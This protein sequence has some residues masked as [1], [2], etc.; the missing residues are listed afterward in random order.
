MRALAGVMVVLGLVLGPAAAGATTHEPQLSVTATNRW[1]GYFES[2]PAIHSASASW[3]VPTLHCTSG[4]TMSSTWVGVGGLN[5]SVLLQAGLFDNCLSGVP[6]NGG[7]AEAYPG[8]TQSFGLLLRPGDRIVATVEDVSGHWQ[9]RVTDATTHHT[10][11]AGA[12]GYS[13]G[14][15]AEWM[16]EAYGQPTYPITNFGSER[17]LSIRVNGA[18]ARPP[19][20]WSLSGAAGRVHPTNPSLGYQLV[21]G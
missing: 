11:S 8:S 19:S 21:Y 17:F 16:A 18:R 20:A 6:V 9:A 13:G 3:R 4:T 10:Q 5:G 2:R 14:G 15:T 1:A 12:P 7:F